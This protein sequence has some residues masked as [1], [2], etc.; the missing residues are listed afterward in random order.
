MLN[1]PLYRV[2][3]PA[4]SGDNRAADNLTVGETIQTL[5]GRGIDPKK[6]VPAIWRADEGSLVSLEN[7]RGAYV[8]LARMQPAKT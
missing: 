8:E 5:A 7:S 1:Q 2:G 3:H 6:I 4:Y